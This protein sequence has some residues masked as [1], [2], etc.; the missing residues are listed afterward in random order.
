MGRRLRKLAA[1]SAKKCQELQHKSHKHDKNVHVRWESEVS[2]HFNIS[3]D[4]EVINERGV[5]ASMAAV[6]SDA[7]CNI[8]TVSVDERDKHLC[9]VTFII[10]IRN[11]LHLARLMKQ[12]RKISSVS[13][14][15]RSL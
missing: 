3:L 10:T 6:I 14:I 7:N 15:Y 5:L 1:S 13:R 9:V 11:R 2:G 8:T 12:L 4:I